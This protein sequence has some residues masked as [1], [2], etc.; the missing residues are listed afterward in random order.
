MAFLPAIIMV[1]TQLVHAT[2]ASLPSPRF[3]GEQGWYFNQGAA[4]GTSPDYFTIAAM[5]GAGR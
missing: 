4:S 1:D 2:K 3:Q 5:I